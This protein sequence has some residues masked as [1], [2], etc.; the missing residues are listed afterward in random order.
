MKMIVVVLVLILIIVVDV[1][2]SR[3]GIVRSLLSGSDDC[4]DNHRKHGKMV[5]ARKIMGCMTNKGSG[6]ESYENGKQCGSQD[7]GGD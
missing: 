7:L 1:E 2:S 6:H 3:H 4:N 5:I